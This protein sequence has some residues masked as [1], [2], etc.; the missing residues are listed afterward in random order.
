MI[1][2][3]GKDMPFIVPDRGK[4]LQRGEL[5][6]ASCR[7][8]TPM[9][10]EVTTRYNELLKAA[11]SRRTVDLVRDIDFQFS[12]TETCVRLDRKTVGRDVFLIQSLCNPVEEYPVDHNY[13]ALL[14]AA[15][16]FRDSGAE[17]VTALL[18]YLA[19]GRQ[20]KPSSNMV[21][22]T[23]ARLMADLSREA[24]IDR[25]VTW[26][27][28]SP[29]IEGFYGGVAVTMLDAVGFF[30]GEFSRFRGKD[31]VVAIA[32]DEGASK[33]VSHFA[34]ALEIRCVVA[35]KHRPYR[36]GPP[37]ARLN[38]DFTGVRTAIVL[39]DIISTAGTV[40]EVIR[41][42]AGTGSINEVYLGV[43]HNLCTTTASGRLLELN[44]GYNL[45]EV[46]VTDSIPQTEE[47]MALPFLSVRSLS[48]V[49][50]RVINRIHCNEAV[51]GAFEDIQSDEDA[52]DRDR[53]GG[54]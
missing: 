18:P 3:S 53:I 11:G 51:G 22:P 25:L 27:P 45:R 31:T 41:A 15:R 26:H 34:S 10:A 49:F 38:G 32:P 35:S 21:E 20:D 42:L 12:D 40:Y 33:F 50:A 44:D 46:V 19:Y 17:H 29:Q 13:M 36:D 52:V 16:T 7:S 54:A 2:P 43:S 47:F 23:T 8:G 48:N 37:V 9:A 24:G 6:I 4:D 39:D 30:A 5:L 28:H 14:I 1:V